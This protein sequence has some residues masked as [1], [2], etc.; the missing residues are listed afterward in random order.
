MKVIGVSEVSSLSLCSSAHTE[1][2]TYIIIQNK[3]KI[4]IKVGLPSSSSSGESS[5]SDNSDDV[6][7][8]IA[9]NLCIN[10]AA[11]PC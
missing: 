1:I 6:E 9:C 2:H 3:Q 4:Y 10:T 11:P 8:V 5:S 7:S